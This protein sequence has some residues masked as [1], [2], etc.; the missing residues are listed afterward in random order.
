[1]GLMIELLYF[2]RLKDFCTKMIIWIISIIHK[3]IIFS[4]V[5]INIVKNKLFL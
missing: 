2:K 1:M 3:I 4:N 5:L